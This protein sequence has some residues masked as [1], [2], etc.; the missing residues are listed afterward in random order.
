MRSWDGVDQVPIR[1]DARGALL[2]GA[3]DGV[4]ELLEET[5]EPLEANLRAEGVAELEAHLGVDNFAARTSAGRD[6][7]FDEVM[8]LALEDGTKTA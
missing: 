7:P 3:A 5:M 6:M 8:A 2:H 1:P 4:F